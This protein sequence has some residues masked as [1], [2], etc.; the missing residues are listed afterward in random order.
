MSAIAITPEIDPIVYAVATDE[1]IPQPKYYYFTAY[2]FRL[3][4]AWYAT[5]LYADKEEARKAA[6][7]KAIIRRKI[8]CVY[9]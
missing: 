9:L 5:N 4:G 1:T 6:S 7:D 2:Q 8:C 3:D